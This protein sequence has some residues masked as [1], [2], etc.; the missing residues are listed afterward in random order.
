MKRLAIYLLVILLAGLS[1][2]LLWRFA[3]SL[4]L[5]LT[6]ILIIGGLL[7]IATNLP[8]S[9]QRHLGRKD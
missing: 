8:P 4:H 3:P 1:F 9:M 5:G 7:C 2:H 6:I